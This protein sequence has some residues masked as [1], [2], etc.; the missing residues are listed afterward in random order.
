MNSQNN[1]Q[2]PPY[3][4]GWFCLIP[5]IG[6]FVGLS[7]LLRGIFK[8][9]DK[10]IIIIGVSGMIFTPLIYSLEY[11]ESRYSSFGKH[12]WHELSKKML[13]DLVRKI[14]TYKIKYGQYPDSLSELRNHDFNALIN[15]PIQSNQ[16]REYTIYN[17]QKVGNKYILFSS[18][19]DG[20]PYTS[21]D[22][23]P[24]VQITDSSKVGLIKPL[25]K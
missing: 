1:K 18:G 15:D 23:F 7:L 16:G 13:V 10:W 6:F 3:W 19:E 24:P 14:E 21:D 5:L 12:G 20:I 17:Y 25:Q 2:K 8:Y 22:I 11:Y 4:V 9:K